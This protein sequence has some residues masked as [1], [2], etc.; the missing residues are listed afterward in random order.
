MGSIPGEPTEVTVS[1]G[2]PNSSTDAPEPG[3]I[4]MK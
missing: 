2:A 4:D 3:T 1:S